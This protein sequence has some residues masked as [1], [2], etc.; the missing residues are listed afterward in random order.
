MHHFAHFGGLGHD[1]GALLVVLFFVLV[2]AA[3]KS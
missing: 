3:V 1:G 2:L